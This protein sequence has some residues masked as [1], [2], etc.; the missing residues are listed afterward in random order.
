MNSRKIYFNIPVNTV[1]ECEF[2]LLI[3]HYLK[4]NV[5]IIQQVVSVWCVHKY[6]ET[7]WAGLKNPVTL[8][9]L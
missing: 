9:S 6:D 5:L 1:P 8:K 7:H 3:K 4:V 2:I